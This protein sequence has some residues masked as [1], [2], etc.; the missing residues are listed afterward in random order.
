MSVKYACDGC[1]TMIDQPIYRGTIKESHYCDTCIPKVD[2]YL[3]ARDALHSEMA[4]LFQQRFDDLKKASREY[5]LARL[6]DE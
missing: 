5:G 2:E 6:P 3:R 4:A 1:G